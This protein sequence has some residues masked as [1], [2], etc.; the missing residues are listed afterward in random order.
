MLTVD[1]SPALAAG[2]YARSSDPVHELQQVSRWSSA[3]LPCPGEG[4]GSGSGGV[5]GEG[6]G[7][8][9]ASLVSP[10]SLMMPPGR[11]QVAPQSLGWT[12]ICGFFAVGTCVGEFFKTRSRLITPRLVSLAMSLHGHNSARRTAA[13]K[14][15]LLT[16]KHYCH[17]FLIVGSHLWCCGRVRERIP[18]SAPPVRTPLTPTLPTT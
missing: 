8:A 18:V 14:A 10:C 2:T 15:L 13:T 16:M 9:A 12:G 5:A 7:A 11:C 17:C 4:S 1:M 6:E 3:R